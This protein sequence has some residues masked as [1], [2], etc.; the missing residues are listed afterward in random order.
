MSKGWSSKRRNQVGNS[1]SSSSALPLQSDHNAVFD[2]SQDD[3][4][5]RD[6]DKKKNRQRHSSSSSSSSNIN[7]NINS[8]HWII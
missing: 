8:K 4:F 7:I 3:V 1:S 6:E 2:W 5:F